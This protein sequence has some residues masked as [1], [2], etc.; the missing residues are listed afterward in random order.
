M[1][2]PVIAHATAQKLTVEA[3][4]RAR[5]APDGGLQIKADVLGSNDDGA[6]VDLTACDGLAAA[7]CDHLSAQGV[8][9][10]DSRHTADFYDGPD[11]GQV[12]TMQQ[13]RDMVN[14]R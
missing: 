4:L 14:R 9:L 12:S 11:R 8:T 2:K 5:I 1:P 13:A 6:S 3:L 10:E 7:L